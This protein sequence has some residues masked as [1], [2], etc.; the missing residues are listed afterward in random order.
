MAVTIT[1]SFNTGPVSLDD[2]NEVR[3]REFEIKSTDPTE[4]KLYT[5][6]DVVSAINEGGALFAQLPRIG[7]PWEIFGYETV[8]HGS[9]AQPKDL[10]GQIGGDSLLCV[11]GRVTKLGA[12]GAGG[13][14]AFLYSAQFSTRPSAWEVTR[15]FEVS[16][17]SRTL[18]ADLDAVLASQGVSQSPAFCTSWTSINI[19]PPV[20]PATDHG[21][22]A[23]VRNGDGIDILEPVFTLTYRKL[24]F[25]PTADALIENVRANILTTNSTVH[26]PDF[27]NL[28]EWLFVGVS[29][30]E[31]RNRV[32]DMTFKFIADEHRHRQFFYETDQG[33]NLPIIVA[34]VPS[35]RTYRGYER[36]NWSPLM[37]LLD[38]A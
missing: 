12:P 19:V 1:E 2:R 36:S 6:N 37:S 33:S 22:E 7:D 8:P 30:G 27:N 10:D 21:H 11:G 15:H 16:T 9:I 38:L 3:V 31:I 20:P 32:Y 17:R 26:P 35:C 14:S 34:G 18:Y 23:V 5:E 24:I 28:D 4:D 13:A 25:S 29:G